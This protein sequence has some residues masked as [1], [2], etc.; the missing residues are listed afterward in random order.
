LDRLDRLDRLNSKKRGKKD[1]RKKFRINSGVKR[2]ARGGYGATPL[3][4]PR[5]PEKQNVIARRLHAVAMPERW[6]HVCC[7][8]ITFE[9]LLINCFVFTTTNSMKGRVNW[10][11]LNSHVRF[12][13]TPVLPKGLVISKCQPQRTCV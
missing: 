13:Q 5:A 12:E 4:L 3:R 8:K 11:P 10:I 6:P 1:F 2:V 9:L 7:V